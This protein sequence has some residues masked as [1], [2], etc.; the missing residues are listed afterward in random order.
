MAYAVNAIDWYRQNRRLVGFGD[1]GAE[2]DYGDTLHTGESLSD[3]AVATQGKCLV[4]SDGRYGACLSGGNLLVHQHAAPGQPVIKVI[5][6]GGQGHYLR[7]DSTG[8]LVLEKSPGYGQVWHGGG[9]TRL[10][11]QNDGNLVVYRA[12]GTAS[13]ASNTQGAA[14]PYPQAAAPAP[15]PLPA[16]TAAAQAAAPVSKALEK[17]RWQTAI[18]RAKDAAAAFEQAKAHYQ[19]A[20]TAANAKNAPAAVA[21]AQEAGS[22]LQQV[23]AKAQAAVDA[24]NGYGKSQGF[25]GFADLFSN[26][27]LPF[28]F[29]SFGDLAD[30]AGTNATAAV[31]LASQVQSLA[32]QAEAANA[33]YQARAASNQAAAQQIA[34]GSASTS[35]VAPPTAAPVPTTTIVQAAPGTTTVLTATPVTPSEPELSTVLLYGG[36]AV[37]TLWLL[38]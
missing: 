19:R 29:F 12:N 24:S 14:A 38:K 1:F 3:L 26:P 16:R 27:P 11:M 7:F 25:A 35:S 22:V 34:A 10:V 2:G 36:L 30:D 37:L 32:D 17:E 13:W 21:L 31:T 8:T 4:S 18:Q 28:S 33:A 6:G 5:G 15:A 9:G 20:A 23:Q